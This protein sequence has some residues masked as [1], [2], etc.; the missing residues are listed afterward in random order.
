MEKQKHNVQKPTNDGNIMTL[1][2]DSD[3][4]SEIW[5]SDMDL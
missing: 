2:E 4:D 3:I 5:K 1:S